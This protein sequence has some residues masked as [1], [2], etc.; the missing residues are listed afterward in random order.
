MTLD[1]PISLPPRWAESLLR[2]LLPPKDRDSVSGDLLE[3]YRES[4]VPLRGAKASR[5]YIRQV[6]WYVLRATWAWSLVVGA[7]CVWR[8]LLDTLVP[9]HYTPGV[10]APRSANE[11]A[12]IPAGPAKGSNPNWPNWLP[13]HDH[14]IRRHRGRGDQ[15]H[16]Q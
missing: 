7:I 1:R 3:E 5:W 14:H 13:P 4:I 16:E 11:A 12:H 9:I 15:R 6:G 8:Y 10:I 2:L